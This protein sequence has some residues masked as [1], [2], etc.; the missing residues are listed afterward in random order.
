MG[1]SNMLCFDAFFLFFRFILLVMVVAQSVPVFS[2]SCFKLPRVLCEHLNMLIRKFWW[3]S[4]EGKRKPHWVSWETMTKPKGMSGLGFKDFELFNLAMLAKQA[5]RLLQKPNSLSA[6]LL[7][8]I[9]YPNVD[10][11]QASLGGHPSQIWRSII[12]G[13]D[14]LKQ[15]LIRRVG[16]GAT[17]NI[18]TDNWLPRKE[19]LQPYGCI[20]ANPPQLV[21]ELIDPT[22]ASWIKQRVNEVFML[23]D[24]T[25]ILGIPLCTRNI[26]DF[27]SWN[28]ETKGIFSVK[29]TYRMLSETKQR[30]EAWLK[31]EPGTSSLQSEERMWKKLWKTEVP[32]KVRM[33]IWRLSKH[34]LPTEDVQAHRHMMTSSSCGLCGMAD[35][36]KHS[37]IQ[38]TM[39]RCV[40]ALVDEELAHKM[41]ALTEPKAK[42]WL[43]ALIESLTHDEFVL[44]SITMWS[45]WHARR[46]AIHEGIFQSPQATQTFINR[47]R[48]ELYMIRPAVRQ[49]SV[50]TA[51]SGPIR[52]KAPPT[53]FAKIHV[54]AAV[55]PGRG[56]SAAA[57]CRDSNETCLGSSALVVEGVDDPA[58]LEALAC[59]EAMCLAEDLLINN[60]IV[61][62]DCKQVV[63]DINSGSR[64]QYR[65]ILSE[66]NLRATLFQCIF[67]SSVM[68]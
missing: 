47:Y 16:N 8:S 9:Y 3:G 40:W 67:L 23:M 31:G 21:S 2:M 49:T 14:V 15:G 66:I 63:S 56:G 62:S 61:A 5:W 27:W 11:L 34:S 55:R 17:T 53:G 13:R 7:K 45:I 6:R 46:K 44:L 54:D 12:E 38:C 35:S 4:K 42:Q 22:S 19:M 50:T 29:S 33:F 57:V 48:D 26:D 20:A 30:C 25:V 60:Y 32:G 58:S 28:F 52:P 24:A 65:A 43:F 37:L 41:L 39:S 68:L 36:W 18:W 64:G 10:I 1:R 59:R 51:P